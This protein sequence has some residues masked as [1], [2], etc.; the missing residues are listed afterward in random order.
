MKKTL[1]MFSLVVCLSCVVQAAQCSGGTLAVYTATSF[2]CTI[3][4][5]TFHDFSYLSSAFG[6]TAAPGASGVAVNPEIVD[7]NV[8][9]LFSS[10]WLAGPGQID[11]SL[12]TYTATCTGCL[13]HNLVLIMAG[14]ASD[15]GLASVS[16]TS[17]SVTPNVSLITGGTHLTDMTTFT[18][19]V[20][21]ITLT[22][23]VGVSGGTDG[24]AN[25]S[26]VSNLFSTV[27][28]MTPEP[29]L[30]LLCLGLLGMIPVARRR[31]RKL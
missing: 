5:V 15:T 22:K 13:I 26:A 12:I 2:A 20:G 14:G 18:T 4:D 1:L 8:G 17:T 11:D 16:E 10:G 31:S 7:G 28:T 9:L 24:F 3:N 19:G 29:P 27:T 23:D 21:S 25:I 6:G 30:I